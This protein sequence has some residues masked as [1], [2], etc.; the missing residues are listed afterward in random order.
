MEGCVSVPRR[1]WSAGLPTEAGERPALP[2]FFLKR[3]R[4]M[5]RNSR[6][7]NEELG[8]F[9]EGNEANEELKSTS[10]VRFCSKSDVDVPRLRESKRIRADE[11]RTTFSGPIRLPPFVCHPA[12]PVSSAQ[13]VVKV[14]LRPF[15]PWL[16]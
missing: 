4:M 16:F 9:T 10:F 5:S 8:D 15:A 7:T 3:N 1:V 13:S 2:T 12:L 11:S 14:L 6:H